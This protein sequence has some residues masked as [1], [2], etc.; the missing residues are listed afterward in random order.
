MTT[1]ELIKL[2][3]SVNLKDYENLKLDFEINKFILVAF[4]GVLI[5]IIISSIYRSSV[6]LLTSRLLRKEA[7]GEDNA[8]T[9]SELG[10]NLF[11][12]RYVLSG[13]SRLKD[14]INRVGELKP[15]YEEYV[16]QM[17]AKKKTP[18]KIDFEEAKFYISLEN[19][20][21]AKEIVLKSNTSVLN[22]ILFCVLLF[23]LTV[24]LIILM[25]EILGWL[26]GILAK[27]V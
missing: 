1:I 4:I 12:I 6:Y 11:R 3:F 10:I 18:D 17:K 5:A 8:M 24:A 7:L 9:L 23:I 14:I 13:N 20:D 22:I 19:T 26:N 2:F 25:P 27:K 16:A 15:T 21:K